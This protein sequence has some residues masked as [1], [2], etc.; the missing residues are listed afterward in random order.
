MG[1]V[2]KTRPPV[3]DWHADFDHF[4]PKF[5]ADPYPIYDELRKECPVAHSERLKG[6]WIPTRY[7]D[8]AA[9][10]HD[11]STFS[12]RQIVITDSMAMMSDGAGYGA[13]PITSD[14]PFHTFFRRLLLPA[15]SPPKVAGW[16]P[17]TR[18]IANE[19]IDKFIERGSC[20]AATEFSQ[21][22]PS[23]VIST[24]LG[25]PP[26][27]D[28]RFTHWIHQLLEVMPTDPEASFGS[29]ME[30]FEYLRL[31]LE[32]HKVEPQDDIITYLLGVQAETT[33]AD[34][35]KIEDATILGACVLL[36]IAGIDTT[37]SSIGSAIWHLSQNP[38]DLKRLVNEPELM[39]TAVEEFLRAY[40]PVTMAREVR[41][42]TEFQGCPMKKGDRLLMPFPSANRDPEMFPNPNEFI[43]DREENRH[44]AFGVGIHRC[45][46]SNLARMELRVAIEEF[47]RRVPEFHL[48]D[49]DEVT[50]SAGSVRGPRCLPI[51][52]DRVA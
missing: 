41:R 44:L 19:L 48:A 50:W 11:P 49:P 25:I 51:V 35:E 33:Q 38:H 10:A 15:F 45:L 2:L 31:K 22:I 32:E 40:S 24:M 12:S 4:D 20:D 28:D 21:Q 27:D 46:G 43:I 1:D 14:P 23:T 8:L 17:R 16:E 34:G 26:E 36:L 52:F 7:E 6:Y 18:K 42:D 39:P 30:M 13:P 47:I 3:Q 29:I 5:V 37:W 9:I